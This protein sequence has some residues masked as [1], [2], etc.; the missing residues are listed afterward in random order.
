MPKF[1]VLLIEDEEMV[2]DVASMMLNRLGCEVEVS[3]T[4]NDAIAT[5]QQN[6]GKYDFLIVD[7]NLPDMTAIECLTEIR[8]TS[9]TPAILSSG[10]GS[11]LTKDECEA[12]V[13]KAVLNKPFSLSQLESVLET[14]SN[15]EQ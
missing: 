13:V 7:F 14:V 1:V 5:M 4:G 12:L 8:K 9:N 10:Y 6:D 15:I 2:I 11:K 3:K